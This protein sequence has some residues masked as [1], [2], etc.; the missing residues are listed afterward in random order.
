MKCAYPSCKAAAIEGKKKCEVHRIKANEACKRRYQKLKESKVCPRCLEPHKGERI[1]CEWCSKI[2]PLENR[3]TY[4]RKVDLKSK[5]GICLSCKSK[6]ING[7]RYCKYHRTSG[8][9]RQKELF[10]TRF[11]N[12]RCRH[13]P[14]PRLKDRVTCS[15]CAE[16][17]NKIRKETSQKYK[18]TNLCGRCGHERDDLTFKL[19]SSCRKYQ[20]QWQKSH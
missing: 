7:S 13:C 10:K 5:A 20:A 19:C 8:A 4:V 1:R 14:K 16:R 9:R 6:S 2:D 12:N 11:L 3:K 18:N 15:D 17:I